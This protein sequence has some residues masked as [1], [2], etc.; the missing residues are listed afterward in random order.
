[1]QNLSLLTTQ[2]ISYMYYAWMTKYCTAVTK[3]G[4]HW[5]SASF[6]ATQRC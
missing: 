2:I 4:K 3:S 5:K 6:P 1:M